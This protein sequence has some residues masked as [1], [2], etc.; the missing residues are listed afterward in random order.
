MVNKITIKIVRLSLLISSLYWSQLKAQQIDLNNIA[1]LDVNR[2][3]ALFDTSLNTN[4][5]TIRNSSIQFNPKI[6]SWK[7]V[8]VNHLSAM[9]VMQ[10]NS[11]LPFG[12]NDGPMI[13]SVGKQNYHN[14]QIGIQ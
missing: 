1:L 10:E 14:F 13:P 6:K 4:S 9:S 12:F 8:F 5:F 7:K 2:V 3:N 11:D